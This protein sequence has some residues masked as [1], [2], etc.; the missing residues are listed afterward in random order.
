[1][2]KSEYADLFFFFGEFE[3]SPPIGLPL[4]CL[5]GG[6]MAD[7]GNEPLSYIFTVQDR[8]PLY[9]ALGDMRCLLFVRGDDHQRLIETRLNSAKRHLDMIQKATRI[10]IADDI[11]KPLYMPCEIDHQDVRLRP[12]R[13]FI[14]Q[15]RD[16]RIINS[17]ALGGIYLNQISPTI[18]S[19]LRQFYGFL[20]HSGHRTGMRLTDYR[21]MAQHALEWHD[22][23]KG[24]DLLSKYK[25]NSPLPIHVPTLVFHSGLLEK[26]TWKRLVDLFRHRIGCVGFTECFI[27]SGMDAA[28][29]VSVVLNKEN[30]LLKINEL[31][32]GIAIKAGHINRTP[33][34][35]QLIVQSRIERSGDDCDFPSSVG[36]TYNIRDKNWIDRLAVVG[37][38]YEDMERKTFIG[39]YMS[40]NLTLDVLEKVGEEKIIT[41]LGLMLKHAFERAGVSVKTL[42][43]IGY[44]GRLIY[45]DLDAKLDELKRFEL[46]FTHDRQRGAYIVPSPVRPN[47]FDMVLINM[48]MDEM[49]AFIRS[50]LINTLSDEAHCDLKGVYS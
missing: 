26:M 28:G 6:I 22:K 2:T 27:K 19:L 14:E 30:F 31:S 23:T 45:P 10:E 24:I 41:L 9:A 17:H 36:V 40:D 49:R 1:M 35:V 44:R 32:D 37:H 50:G 29:E 43:T 39:C 38:V 7:S 21:Y 46:L 18:Y 34:E 48:E 12:T 11:P 4:V 16:P 33:R 42:M 20:K 25:G 13:S 5:N 8:Y 3:E 47:S 15:V